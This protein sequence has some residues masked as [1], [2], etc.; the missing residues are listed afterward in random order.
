MR[1]SRRASYPISPHNQKRM[2][3]AVAMED[4]VMDSAAVDKEGYPNLDGT[5]G[6]Q[7]TTLSSRKPLHST[8]RRIGRELQSIF[9]IV[10]LG[11]AMTGGTVS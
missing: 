1:K 5:G 6:L 10:P 9:P 4:S 11:P 7:R 3:A 2:T 8:K